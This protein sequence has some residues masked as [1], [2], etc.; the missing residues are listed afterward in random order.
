MEYIYEQNGVK[1]RNSENNYSQ[2][3][4]KTM[5][6]DFNIWVYVSLRRYTVATGI[7]PPTW[8]VYYCRQKDVTATP[9]ITKTAY[10]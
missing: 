7:V 5:Y 4:S 6:F 2:V 10:V 3:I 1:M 8:G 9:C